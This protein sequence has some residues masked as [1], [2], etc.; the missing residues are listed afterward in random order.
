MHGP[1]NIKCIKIKHF[2]HQDVSNIMN[3]HCTQYAPYTVSP[4][5][6]RA[7]VTRTCRYKNTVPFVAW[8]QCL[9][10]KSLSSFIWSYGH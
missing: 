8:K 5:L 7:Q 6:K 2:S 9:Y 4:K 10:V 1:L 3:L